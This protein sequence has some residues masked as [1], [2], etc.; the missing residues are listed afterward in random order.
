MRPKW[1]SSWRQMLSSALPP[2]PVAVSF[3]CSLAF[4]LLQPFL[5]YPSCPLPGGNTWLHVFVPF[6]H[7]VD[8]WP[9]LRWRSRRDS[10]WI[11]DVP[12][13]FIRF[14]V[15]RHKWVFNFRLL[16]LRCGRKCDCDCDCGRGSWGNCGNM[17]HRLLAEHLD[18]I[19]CVSKCLWKCAK[20]RSKWTTATQHTHSL[21]PHTHVHSWSNFFI[22][23][24]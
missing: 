7:A 14:D 10:L 5:F 13:V 4:Y 2:R 16:S 1:P 9:K 24:V 21:H 8:T 18:T 17:C 15:R 22:A 23:L 3:P 6:R 19:L 20:Q 12:I 11:F